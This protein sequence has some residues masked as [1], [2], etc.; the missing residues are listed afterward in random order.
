MG[1]AAVDPRFAEPNCLFWCIG[2]QKAGTTWLHSYLADHP[3]VLVPS[4]RKELQYW[5]HVRP[6]FDTYG[7]QT[8]RGEM[9]KNRARRLAMSVLKGEEG[10]R[11]ARAWA[12]FERA[13]RTQDPAHV[14]YANT[15]FAFFDG[16]R[17]VGE[18]S[19]EYALLEAETLQEMAALSP[20]SR[21]IYIMRDPVE[22]M[23][24]GIRFALS[25]HATV[26]P[27]AL[28]ERVT[29][30]LDD[31]DPH[32]DFWRTRYDQVISKLDATLPRDRV[33]YFFYETLFSEQEIARLTEF[34]G[35]D[36]MPADF[37]RKVW[38]TKNREVMP[39][40][41]AM[42]R[43]KDALQPVY[44][45]VEDRFGTELPD[46]WKRSFGATDVT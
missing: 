33:A 15:L 21:M 23:L 25:R 1:F 8:T 11:K 17:A 36:P 42:T 41:T 24:S 5:N 16:H 43:V 37:E 40:S 35:V 22:R 12:A 29:L 32:R 27:E 28:D 20:K 10:R 26:T 3:Q 6:P 38:V 2:A 45:F 7:T 30:A 34:L 19:P 13:L 39:S 14:D 9:L 4:V 31:G 18:A 46:R 44:R